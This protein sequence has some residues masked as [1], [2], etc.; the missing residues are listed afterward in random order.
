V[1][2]HVKLKMGWEAIY[3]LLPAGVWRYSRDW[4]HAGVSL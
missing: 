4:I 1:I 2:H 3:S